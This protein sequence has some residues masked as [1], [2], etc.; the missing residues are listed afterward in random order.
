VHEEFLRKMMELTRQLTDIEDKLMVREGA[1]PSVISELSQ[2]N[3]L[4]VDEGESLNAAMVR[5]LP[6]DK[7]WRLRHAQSGGEALDTASQS[8]PQILVVRENLPDLPASMI[9]KTIKARIPDVVALMF[10][11]PHA[12]RAGEVHMVD[13]SKLL[14]LIPA[15]SVPEQ[16]VAQL[17]ELRDALAKKVKERRYLQIFRK[18]HFDFLQKYQTLRQRLGAGK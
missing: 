2:V 7:G 11:A 16:M 4:L 13:S 18:Q 17:Q 12:G 6:M 14:T 5:D 8:P 10:T 9:I 1:T 15:F 3:V